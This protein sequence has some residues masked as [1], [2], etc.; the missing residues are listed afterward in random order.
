M[1]ILSLESIGYVAC[2]GIYRWSRNH[3]TFTRFYK[4]KACNHCISSPKNEQKK[5]KSG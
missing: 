2:N 5:N 3:I 4:K 1:R